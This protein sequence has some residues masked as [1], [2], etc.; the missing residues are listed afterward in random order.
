MRFACLGR[1]GGQDID[2][3][4]FP[5]SPLYLATA[6]FEL[7]QLIGWYF[8]RVCLDKQLSTGSGTVFGPDTGFGQVFDKTDTREEVGLTD[9]TDG[10]VREKPPHLR[11]QL[12]L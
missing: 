4:C 3:S 9:R 7:R 1:H 8:V 12:V 10:D 2:M 6:S 5:R 11:L